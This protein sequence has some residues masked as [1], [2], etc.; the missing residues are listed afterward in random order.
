MKYR[1]CIIFQTNR[2]DLL[3]MHYYFNTDSRDGRDIERKALMVLSWEWYTTEEINKAKK[4][5]RF[6][7][8]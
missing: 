4:Y 2:D 6:L 7:V 3:L 5:G 1:Y 8:I